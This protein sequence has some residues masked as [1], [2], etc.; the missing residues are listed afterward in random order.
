MELNVGLNGIDYSYGNL[1]CEALAYS[2]INILKTESEKNGIKLKYHF[3]FYK[4]IDEEIQKI[5]KI[6]NID[7]E[8]ISVTVMKLKKINKTIELINE[9]KKCDFIIDMSGGDSFS[10]IYGLKRMIKESIYKN[11]AIKNKIP[12][13]LGPQTYGPYNKKISKILAKNILN[14]ATMV[15]SRDEESAM[16]VKEISNIEPI[17]STDLALRLPYSKNN[18]LNGKNIGINISALM[19]YEGYGTNNHFGISLDYREYIDK[20]IEFLKSKMDYKIYLISHVNANGI[21]KEDDYALCSILSKKYEINLAPKFSDPIEAK[22]FISDLDILIG[23]RM[24]ATIAAFSSSVPTIPVAYSKKFEGLYKSLNYNY[25]ID[26]K[27]ETT[28]R[29]LEKTINFI[30]NIEKLKS[31]VKESLKTAN[32]RLSRFD[33]KISDFLINLEK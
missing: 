9:Y 6:F 33:E 26:S 13:I 5:S 8:N 29:A 30:E 12:I 25:Y 32:Y 23:S 31:D 11:I 2:V 4:K 7:R 19:W 20:L 17:V 16:L 22:S 15:F 28:E 18:M 21:D 10:D 3:F 24:H 27:K 1:G 14:K